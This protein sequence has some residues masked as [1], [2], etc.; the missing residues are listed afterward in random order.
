VCYH[1]PVVNIVQ[2]E[3]AH[4]EHAWVKRVLFLVCRNSCMLCYKCSLLRYFLLPVNSSLSIFIRYQLSIIKTLNNSNIISSDLRCRLWCLP[5]PWRG[6]HLVIEYMV[7]H[8]KIY[9][10]TECKVIRYGYVFIFKFKK[11]NTNK[12]T[13]YYHYH[14]SPI[15]NLLEISCMKLGFWFVLINFPHRQMNHT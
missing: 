6:T 7:S 15:A 12:I 3:S 9:L 5:L 11:I 2:C 4:R 14:Q 8:L 10:F 1:H 13:K